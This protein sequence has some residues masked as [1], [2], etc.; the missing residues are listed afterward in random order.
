MWV[1]LVVRA[2]LRLLVSSY[3]MSCGASTSRGGE[4]CCECNTPLDLVCQERSYK[5]CT[6]TVV[7]HASLA[8]IKSS[9]EG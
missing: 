7:V 1:I 3:R 2:D 9:A 5:Y 4:M 6:F 8:N